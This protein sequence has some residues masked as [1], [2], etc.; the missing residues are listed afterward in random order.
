[1]HNF[2][3]REFQVVINYIILQIRQAKM[4]VHV[5]YSFMFISVSN[6][7]LESKLFSMVLSEIAMSSIVLF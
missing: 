4:L 6:L 5:L 2:T 1:M 3:I 7:G